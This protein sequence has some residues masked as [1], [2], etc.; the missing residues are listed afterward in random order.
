M[1]GGMIKGLITG[2]LVGSA[3][4]TVF[5]IMNLRTERKWY[6]QAQRI[7]NKMVRRADDLFGR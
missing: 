1:R 2:A 4:A 7:S 6:Q 5:G 3:A